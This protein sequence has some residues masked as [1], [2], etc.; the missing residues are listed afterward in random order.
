MTCTLACSLTVQYYSARSDCSEQHCLRRSLKDISLVYSFYAQLDA[1][2]NEYWFMSKNLRQ[3]GKKPKVETK[4]APSKA[5][6]RALRPARR[7]VH[8][9][10]RTFLRYI[11]GAVFL[12]FFR[13]LS[14]Y[15]VLK[16]PHIVNDLVGQNLLRPAVNFLDERQVL[17]VATMSSGTTQVAVDL[18]QKLGLE[19]GHENTDALD[20]YVR[21]GTASWFHGIRFFPDTENRQSI[22]HNLCHNF[23]DKMGYH[24][25]QYHEVS[26]CSEKKPWFPLSECWLKDCLDI[27]D[28]EWG[29]A[30][31]G[32]C[33]QP[34]RTTLLQVRDPRSVVESLLAKFCM[35]DETGETSPHGTMQADWVKFMNILFEGMGHDFARYSCI[36]AV[37]TYVIEYNNIM[38]RAR[39]Q[40]LID[41]I[42]K[43]ETTSPCNIAELAGFFS[44]P[45]YKPNS[46]KLI[47]KCSPASSGNRP[48]SATTNQINKGRIRL[49]WADYEK[50]ALKQ[51]MEKLMQ[52]LDY[53]PDKER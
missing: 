34:F 22:I 28:M 31:Q 5:T 32:N 30:A 47:D 8:E 7:D 26:G 45:V 51:E 48:M 44:N 25:R 15:I 24:P 27:L 13:R 42:Y 33:P 36:E 49:D 18:T 38:L 35:N 1:P 17:I 41:G 12:F 14:H 19:I 21:D 23:T 6:K 46:R 53:D 43:V 4:V 3:R 11:V 52:S 40:N 20:F 10:R 16:R 50:H 37:A 9:A 29:C 39:D 2:F